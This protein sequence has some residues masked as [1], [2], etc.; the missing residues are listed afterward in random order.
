M[1][2]NLVP[3]GGG[4]SSKQISLGDTYGDL[5]IPYLNSTSAFVGWQQENVK[6]QKINL[7]EVWQGSATHNGIT[8]TSLD[9]GGMLINGTLGNEILFSNPPNAWKNGND[10]LRDYIDLSFFEVGKS[11][12]LRSTNSKVKGLFQ[13]DK[14]AGS[15]WFTN[16]FKFTG[17]ELQVSV[18]P[19]IDCTG[20]GGPVVESVSNLRFY[21]YLEEFV[22][23]E[24]DMQN[25]NLTN[26][27]ET[28]NAIWTRN[29]VDASRFESNQFG[30]SWLYIGNGMIKVEGLSTGNA[31]GYP[32]NSVLVD[33]KDSLNGI[34]GQEFIFSSVNTDVKID[35][36]FKVEFLN[37]TTSYFGGKYPCE[38]IGVVSK[39]WLYLEVRTNKIS[40][41]DII[42]P[43]LISLS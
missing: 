7:G 22:P 19:Q 15:N 41:D 9:D 20:H 33:V 16:V 29:W 2:V 38:D 27:S 14:A 24:K 42:R 17:N 39:C 11:Y 21:L 43:I 25:T 4:V 12:C 3:Q 34:S 37:G 1:V 28:A 13:L 35:Y 6:S 23:L 40:Y 10:Y 18:Y 26:C 5:P 32:A 36:L 8:W 30:I 31:Y